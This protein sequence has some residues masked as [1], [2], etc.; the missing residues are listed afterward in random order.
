MRGHAKRLK[1]WSGNLSL[2]SIEN[3]S[4]LVKQTNAKR[5]IDYGSGKGYQYLSRR[6]HEGWGGILPYCYDIGVWQL[7]KKPE[8]LFDGV[9]CTDVMEH[10]DEHDIDSILSDILSL[11]DCERHRGAFAYFNVFCN[12]AS[13][14]WADGRNVHLTVKPPEWWQE[15]FER[16]R[17]S[18]IKLWVD[19]EYHRDNDIRVKTIR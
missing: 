2:D 11:L 15:V 3:I 18:N 6:A 17:C 7:N 14:H 9:I 13:K 4:Y 16:Y 10:I 5:L 12:P 19:Y 8:G 1:W